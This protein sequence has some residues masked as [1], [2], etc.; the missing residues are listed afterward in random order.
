MKK[1][2]SCC[3]SVEGLAYMVTEEEKET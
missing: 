3:K 2:I 1:E